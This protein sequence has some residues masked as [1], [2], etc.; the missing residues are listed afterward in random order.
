MLARLKLKR[1]EGKLVEG[2]EVGSRRWSQRLPQSPP[3]VLPQVVFE[4]SVIMSHE[5][6]PTNMIE[7]EK[8]FRKPFFDMT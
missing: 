3:L 1:G 2:P 4:A 7:D 5:G 8:V 6:E